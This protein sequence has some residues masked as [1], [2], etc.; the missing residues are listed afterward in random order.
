LKTWKRNG[1]GYPRG[2]TR[3]ND[4]E[5]AVAASLQEVTKP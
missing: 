3:S 4:D 5:V 2:R 1:M